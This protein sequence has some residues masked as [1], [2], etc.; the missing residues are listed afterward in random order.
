MFQVLA[1]D[2]Q[3]DPELIAEYERCHQHIWPEVRQLLYEYGI[4]QLQLYRLGTRLVMCLQT[5]DQRFDADAYQQAQRDHPVL[6]DWESLMDGFQK[7]TPWSQAG[8]KWTPMSCIFEL[9]P[10]ADSIAPSG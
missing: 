9:N 6:R 4:E 2:L 7:A 3:D 8:A 1:L 10:S 5:D